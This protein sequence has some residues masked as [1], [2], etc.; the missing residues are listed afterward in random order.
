[1]VATSF[2]SLLVLA[3]SALAIP[4]RIERF[5]SRLERRGLRQGTPNARLPGL[6]NLAANA[7]TSHVQYSSNWAGAVYDNKPTVST[8]E[9]PLLS[10]YVE[11]MCDVGYLQERDGHLHSSQADRYGIGICLGWH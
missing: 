1:M 3:A 2:F 8:V 6:N 4:S 9:T 10:R 5:A 11:F 7:T